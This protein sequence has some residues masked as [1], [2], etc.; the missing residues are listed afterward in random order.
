MGGPP[1]G[2]GFGW[3]QNGFPPPRKK[4]KA[5]WIILPVALVGIVVVGFVV[6]SS[7]LKHNSNDYSQPETTSPDSPAAT[8]SSEAPT[9]DPTTA[10]TTTQVTT[11][12]PPP[13]TRTTRTT[14][15]P[16]TRTTPAAPSD[17]AIVTKNRIYKTGVMKTVN[18]REPS[19][20]PTTVAN[21]RKY[22]VG[23]L[24]CLL[25]AWPRQVQAAGGR[26]VAP[27]LVAFAGHATSPCSGNLPSSF[28][29]PSNRTIYMDAG[30]DVAFWR[31]Y[32]NVKYQTDW[33]RMHMA[34]T[35][36]HEFGHHVQAMVGILQAQ[37]NLAY[38]ASPTKA[39]EISRRKELQA[40]CFGNV[41][42]GA[43]RSS[44]GITGDLKFQLTYLHSHQG[45]EYGTQPD[46]GSRLVL[47]IWTNAAYASRSPASCN[48]FTASA[49]LVR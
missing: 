39:L 49:Y 13:A 41:F 15:P 11:Q 18:C 20:R 25:R 9:Y 47:P 46:H 4:S 8:P 32:S 1:P 31:Q 40:S 16:P 42:L 26:F 17:N 27:N 43:N 21:A 37:Q 48:T 12:A 38:S 24:N 30:T 35:T 6:L 19:A 34:D 7:V 22:Y 2:P 36:A 44:L 10:Q 23:I 5:V 33:K 45:D 28:Y 3:G 29:C 14:Q